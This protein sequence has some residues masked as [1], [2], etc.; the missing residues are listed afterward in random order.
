M[1]IDSLPPL[2][3]QAMLLAAAALHKAMADDWHAAGRVIERIADECGATG[4]ARAM[5][6]WCDTLIARDP[7]L[8]GL[9][10]GGA[11]MLVFK[12]TKSG[13]IDTNADDVPPCA[14]WAGR[15]V[16]ARAAGDRATWDALMGAV[17]A[18]EQGAHVSA[19]L[20]G[21]ALSLRRLNE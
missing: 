5:L 12:E 10:E 2:Q 18:D 11:V 1:G 15:M 13:R 17:P 6:G 19:V 3:Q 16:A 14:R 20:E 8:A 7:A 9:A 21:V 4:L